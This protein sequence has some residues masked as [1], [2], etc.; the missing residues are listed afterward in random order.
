MEDQ[1]SMGAY[2]RWLKSA[3]F[4]CTAAWLTTCHSACLDGHLAQSVALRRIEIGESVKF[5][6]QDMAG[7][8]KHILVTSFDL[9]G[10]EHQKGLTVTIPNLAPHLKLFI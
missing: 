9:L 7:I 8:E 6:G 2:L 4:G 5:Q 3:W 10:T 1:E